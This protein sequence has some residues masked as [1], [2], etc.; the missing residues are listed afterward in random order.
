MQKCKAALNNQ[1]PTG[2]SVTCATFL[3]THF[4]RSDKVGGHMRVII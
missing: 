4:I 1:F 2:T 3:H